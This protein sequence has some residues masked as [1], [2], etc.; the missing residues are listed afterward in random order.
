[1]I[2]LPRHSDFPEL[3][4]AASGDARA[5]LEQFGQS[6]RGCVSDHAIPCIAPTKK[7]ITKAR[8]A[9]GRAGV[10]CY[11]I[12]LSVLT[13]PGDVDH[14]TRV[15]TYKALTDNYY[16]PDSILL[17]LLPLAMRL[18]G[19]REALVACTDPSKL[20]RQSSDRR[21]RLMPAPVCR[22]AR[23]TFLRC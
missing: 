22:L 12:P 11:C 23:Q 18:A 17:S 21:T 9:T 2:Q 7:E 13:K 15:R 14:Y 4:F 5:R 3:R 16:A 19:P 1:V 8:S 10:C 20:W 6:A